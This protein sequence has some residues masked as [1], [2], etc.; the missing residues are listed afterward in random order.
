ME[1]N[2]EVPEIQK[3]NINGVELTNEDIAKIAMICDYL[4][5]D[6]FHDVSSFLRLEKCFGP[7]FTKENPE[8]LPDVFKEICGEKKK[9]IT[10]GRLINAYTKWK[11]KSSTNENFNKFMD[12]VFGDIIKTQNEVVGKLV[13][14]GRIFST[15]NTRGRKVISKFSVITDE[16]KS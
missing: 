1:A 7:F 10:F 15:R 2:E 3:K 8:F 5:I 13:E 9:Y 4:V 11:S 12:L 6:R 16:T 14:G